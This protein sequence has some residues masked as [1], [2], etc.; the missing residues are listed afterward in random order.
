M[1][2]A[3][4]ISRHLMSLYH[5]ERALHFHFEQAKIPQ[6]HG[7]AQRVVE[8]LCARVGEK[9]LTLVD[10]S[11]ELCMSSRTLQRRLQSENITFLQILERVRH[12][13]ALQMLI[14]KNLRINDIYASLY[15]AD[16]SSF[17]IAFKRWTG[18]A[19]EVFRRLYRDCKVE[20]EMDDDA[21]STRLAL[22]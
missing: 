12:H 21:A 14:N 11:H 2:E 7:T 16:R 19:P 6:Y 9:S 20:E 22:A 5:R 1:S 4:D 10:I 15:Y 8:E 3:I 13:Y 17:S 18:L